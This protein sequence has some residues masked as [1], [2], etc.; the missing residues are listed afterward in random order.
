MWD[1]VVFVFSG[2]FMSHLHGEGH[3]SLFMVLTTKWYCG[4]LLRLMFV[5]ILHLI[6]KSLLKQIACLHNI[7]IDNT[8]EMKVM[9]IVMSSRKWLQYI[10]NKIG[11]K[12]L[13]IFWNIIDCVLVASSCVWTLQLRSHGGANCQVPLKVTCL[14]SRTVSAPWAS[15]LRPGLLPPELA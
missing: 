4:S 11:L 12:M 14:L 1:H 8:F 7:F 6:F 3:K 2:K 13:V 5:T 9:F 10:C 15:C